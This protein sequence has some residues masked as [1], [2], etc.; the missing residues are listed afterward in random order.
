MHQPNSFVE[1]LEF[2]VA[3]EH[4]TAFIEAD[5]AVWTAGLA[6]YP[7]FD[8]K[9]IWFGQDAELVTCVI[10]WRDRVGWKAISEQELLELGQEFD[11]VFPYL[12]TLV[13]EREYQKIS[14]I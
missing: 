2:R 3:P 14:S 12:Y 9:E 6:K 8:R 13:G 1:I 5:R 4:Q 11:R 7:A 10:Y